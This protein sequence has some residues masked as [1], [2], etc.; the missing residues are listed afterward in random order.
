MTVQDVNTPT[1]VGRRK[2]SQGS[3]A[4]L[5]GMTAIEIAKLVRRRDVSPVEV[6]QAHLERIAVLEPEIHAFQ[7]IRAERA[8]AEAAE[9]STRPDLG[10]LPLAGVPVAIKDNLDV[11]GEPTRQGSAATSDHLAT[12]DDE[13]VRRLRAAGC[14]A[15]GKTVMPELAVWPFT[16]PEAFGPPTR[17][18]WNHARTPGGST[19]GGGAAVAAGMAPLAVGSDG[20]GSLRVPAACCGVL[21]LKPSPGLVP[22]AGGQSQ[23]WLGLTEF[24]P[25]ANSVADLGLMLDVLAQTTT[26]RFAAPPSRPLRIAVSTKPP[27]AGARVSPEVKAAVARAAAA[28]AGVG[29]HVIPADPPYPPD[30]GF[31]FMGRWLSGIAA[32]AHD[33]PEERLERR[34][35]SMAHVGRWLERLGWAKLTIAD[36][37][38]QHVLRWFS[39]YDVLLTATLAEPAGSIG[40]WQGKGWIST[41]LGIA[42]WVF[43]TPWNLA[44]F[45]A[46]S[47]PA[48]LSTDGLPLAV[49][50]VVPPG[51]E[52]TILAILGQ[53]EQ[54]LPWPRWAARSMQ[55]G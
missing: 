47:V 9:L 53:I 49:Q 43:T 27:A 7:I 10:D 35:R 11:S 54:L 41:T 25:L 21:G 45:P 55:N 5:A 23:H 42:N 52:G 24:G 46:A 20:G 36:G 50:V 33:L 2:M 40:R 8:L 31:R 32:D 37:F 48:G 29:H 44:G 6:I 22:L 28:L 38:A 34:T 3:G 19:G 18:P 26:F 4:G 12:Q 16:E 17:N 39:S 30:L 51:Q 14:I 1:N 13:L 15:I